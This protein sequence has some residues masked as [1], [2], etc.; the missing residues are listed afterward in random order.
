MYKKDRN[1]SK[2]PGTANFAKISTYADRN[3]MV[4]STIFDGKPEPLGNSVNYS[5]Q[6]AILNITRFGKYHQE[7]W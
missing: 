4:E 1:L 5:Q 7:L 3:L 6:Y 2:E